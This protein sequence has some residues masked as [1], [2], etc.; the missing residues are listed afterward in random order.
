MKILVLNCGSSSVKYQ[1]LDMSVEPDLLAK[2]LVERIGLPTGNLT[3]KAKGKDKHEVEKP[4]EDHTVAIDLILET[5]TNS[6]TGVI[7][8]INEITAAGHRVA[9]GGENFTKS[10]LI[11]N[12]VKADIERCIELAPLHN[13]ANLKG[14]LSLEKLLPQIPQVAVFDTSFH[15]SMPEKSYLYAIPYEYYEK[16][17]IRRYGFH[18]TSHKFVAEKACNILGMD[19]NNSRIITCH[20]G[21]GASIAAI[22]NGKSM[23]TTMGFTPVEGLVMGTRSGDVG[24][25]VVFYLMEKEGLSIKEANDLINK[26]SGLK[27]LSGISS[28]MRDICNAAAEGNKRA[29]IAFDVFI[30]RIKKYV[31]AYAMELG[32]IDLLIFTGGIG[33][34]AINVRE[35][36]C[37]GTEFLGIEFD[38][39]KN[40]KTQ[41]VDALISKPESKTKVM[42]VTTNEELVIATDTMNIVK[43]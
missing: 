37:E 17:Q 11:T 9:H 39:S 13:P 5:L 27:G 33:E 16:Y 19:F 21:N 3:H 30:N 4:I 35:A 8:N 14:I 22:K 25:G 1:L 2:G 29:Q 28:D 10:A 41:G 20:L 34:N 32:G 18:G 42:A 36:V 38:K 26:K 6:E 43:N 40:A 15:Q 12:E 24:L 23:D 31:G 7:S